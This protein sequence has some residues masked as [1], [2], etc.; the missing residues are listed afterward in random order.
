M[1]IHLPR[2]H[3]QLPTEV[4]GS[5]GWQRLAPF[6]ELAVTLLKHLDGIANYCRTNVR[7]GAVEAVN[8]NIRMLITRAWLQEPA[9]PAAQGQAPGSQ[10]PR[11]PRCAQNRESRVICTLCQILAQ[12]E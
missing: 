11:T 10:E 5:T 8:G 1:E 4:D 2:S 7:M 3:D 9:L 12:S 6:E